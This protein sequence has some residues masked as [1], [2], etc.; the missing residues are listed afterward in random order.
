MMRTYKDKF[1]RFEYDL[2]K[3]DGFVDS[4]W[5]ND[6]CPSMWNESKQLKLFCDYL[7]ID[8]RETTQGCKVFSLY[9]EIDCDLSLLIESDSIDEIKDFLKDYDS[10]K[11]FYCYWGEGFDD[12]KTETN[13][14]YFFTQANG[15]SLEDIKA[16]SELKIHQEYD[17][18]AITFTHMITRAK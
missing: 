10:Q 5:I 18:S 9:R 3:L 12:E 14:I 2:P 17:A 4:S 15:Y 6:V 16:I 8:K 11:R 7:D 13:D 1:P